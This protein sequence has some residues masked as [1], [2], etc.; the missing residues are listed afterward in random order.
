M[1]EHARSPIDDIKAESSQRGKDKGT[2]T[3]LTTLVV[4]WLL[5]LAVL[6]AVSWNAYFKQKDAALTL[7]QQISF[8]CK[9]GDFGPGIT[10]E[11]EDAI[12]NNAKKVIQ[13]QAPT[14]GIQGP[15]GPQGIQGPPGPQ[16]VQGL[17]GPRGIKGDTGK[18]GASGPIGLMGI[19]GPQ[20]EKGDKGDQGPKGDTGDQGPKGDTGVIAVAT[21]GCD[22]PLIRSLTATYDPTTQTLTIT[23]T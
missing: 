14:Q 9:S 16:G 11:N 22:G 6:I 23:C 17:Q 12:C 3:A 20:G 13:D 18:I 21:Q 7:A 5:T 2:R 10:Q 19:Q 4:L 8:A 1:S 15:R